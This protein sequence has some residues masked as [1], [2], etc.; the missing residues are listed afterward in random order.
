MTTHHLR[1]LAP[2]GDLLHDAI[3]LYKKNP[4]L[5]SLVTVIPFVVGVAA[6]LFIDLTPVGTDVSLMVACGVVALFFG[7]LSL[8]VRTTHPFAYFTA[9]KKVQ[10]GHEASAT[11]VYTEAFKLFWPLLWISILISLLV[12][13]GISLFIVPAIFVL[14]Y[15][16]FTHFAFI[17]DK[18]RGVDAVAHS[19]W[20]VRGYAW[21]IFGYSILMVVLLILATLII[22]LVGTLLAFPLGVGLPLVQILVGM[23]EALFITPITFAFY[24]LLYNEVKA[25]KSHIEATEKEVTKIKKIVV[26][27]LIVS[28]LALVSILTI[29]SGILIN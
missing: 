19:I 3:G 4:N 27:L 8:I 24:Y 2:F 17:F 16:S 11:A 29:V 28:S 10:Q 20:L 5:L 9:L 23:I 21:D 1:S 12:A 18:K 22:G 6:T 25:A 15:V 7:V 13:G 26:T 14:V